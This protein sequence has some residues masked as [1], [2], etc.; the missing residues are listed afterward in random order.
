MC[1]SLRPS[2]QY[3][4]DDTRSIDNL[5]LKGDPEVSTQAFVAHVPRVL[6]SMPFSK[7][8]T[9]VLKKSVAGKYVVGKL[10]K[11]VVNKY[12]AGTLKRDSEKFMTDSLV[13][14]SV[15]QR[16]AQL[17]WYGLDYLCSRSHSQMALFPI[18]LPA[19]FLD[20]EQIWTDRMD[21]VS[22]QLEKH[23]LG[24]WASVHPLSPTAVKHDLAGESRGQ[25]AGELLLSTG[26]GVGANLQSSG[27][28]PT[29]N[30]SL[31]GKYMILC[32]CLLFTLVLIV[33]R[34]RR[35]SHKSP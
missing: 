21:D 10:K 34:I 25:G 28:S 22:Y 17:W 12:V 5:E 15:N 7:Y 29:L 35:C 16:L 13:T 19:R 23:P 32:A 31:L 26:E 33:C 11:Y 30:D 2:V 8:V 1:G 3:Q 24:T 4:D 18:F 14:P 9:R 6:A 27:S 20:T